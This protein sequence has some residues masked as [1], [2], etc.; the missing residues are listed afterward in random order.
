MKTEYVALDLETTGLDP[1]SDRIIEIGAV[2]FDDNGT[3]GTFQTLANPGR[4]V[5]RVVQRLTGITDDEAGRAPPIETVAADLE[6]FLRGAVLVGHNVAGF[7][8]P[9]LDRAGILRGGAAYDTCDL[10]RILLPGLSEYGLGPL[11]EHFGITFPV[12]HR[13]LEDAEASRSLF[14][15]LQERAFALPRDVLVQAARWLAPTAWPWK[16]FFT[17]ALEAS[18]DRGGPNGKPARPAA[19][20]APKQLSHEPAPR[21]VRPD[22]ALRVL[23]S[24]AKRPDVFP[25]FDERPQQQE[26]VRAVA[27]A[28]SSGGRLMVEA[29]TG[30][31]KSLAYLVPAACH[32]VASGER[33]VVS[34]NTINL[35]E[36][37]L[38]KD[39]PAVQALLP[40][41]GTP[42]R[43]CQ[44]KGRRN[45]LCLHRFWALGNQAEMGDN[46][47]LLASRIRV[48]LCETETG[49]R[50]ELKLSPDEE[51]IWPRLS[52]D[53]ADCTAD[54]SAFVADGSCFLQRARRE[55]EAAHIV[56]VNHSLLLS[57]AATDG[58]VIP[59]YEHLVIDEA[60]HLEDEAT[61][62]FGFTS[63]ERAVSDLLGRCEDLPRQVQKGL[64]GLT[65]ALGPHAELT[66]VVRDLRQAADAA[67]PRLKEFSERIGAFRREHS[68]GSD[69]DQ[70]LLVVR[71]VRAQPDWVHVEVAWENLRLSLQ[72]VVAQL[73]KFH[74]ALSGPEANQMPNFE[75]LRAEA[76][77][78]L[79]GVQETVIGMAAAIE[80]DDPARIVWLETQR[81]DGSPIVAWVPLSV[82]ET[83]RERL[84]AEK[85][86]I[87]LTGATLQTRG[88][89]AYL[90]QRLGL[91]DAD[92]VALGSPFDFQ[93]AALVLVPRDMPEPNAPDY[94]RGLS[95]SI[96]ELTK[97]SRGRALVLFTSY[98]S[99][100]AAHKLAADALRDE[101]IDALA[102]GA[103]GSP[104]QL[105]RALQ[106][107]PQTVIFGTASFWEGVDIAG[108]ALSL[109][110][111]TRLPFNVPTDPVHAARS[112]AYDEPFMQYTLPQAI[113]R[114][115]QGFGRL[116]RAKTDRGVMVVLDRRIVSKKYGAAF[117]ESLPPCPVREA[118]LREMPELVRECLRIEDSGQRTVDSRPAR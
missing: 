82:D 103:D 100:R 56:A 54:R 101:G 38:K 59:P 75:M 87:V 28:L 98:S 114:F 3:L 95:E 35:Q 17:W 86:T 30:T 52:A 44:L 4:P 60:H 96:V 67:R 29:G 26:M 66:A 24:A 32:A 73:K 70:R 99:L 72:P 102:Q 97:A 16:G 39:I 77:A 19:S 42:L 37:L 6:E 14:L 49:D 15:I 21:P 47:A 50:S 27:T 22:E 89:F 43:A 92:T 76:D 25:E 58:R 46:E 9:F 81:S 117:L 116:I 68:E 8:G 115:K 109:L 118:L 85:A 23:A 51:A 93:K 41:G 45:Y 12:R 2:R 78:L 33:V 71:S 110:I 90:Q 11:C 20:P 106:A 5:P 1:D 10:A 53:G 113:L 63:G 94:L 62:Q 61:R 64:R 13:A 105:V 83:L 65:L 107:N 91:D 108:E 40:D 80:Q 57:D 84:Y 48:W 34:T 112:A 79:Q 88:S 7:D 18:A 104:R 111:M 31:G 74:A 55:A 69:P 36:Q